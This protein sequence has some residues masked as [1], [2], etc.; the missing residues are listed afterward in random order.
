MNKPFFMRAFDVIPEMEIAVCMV[1]VMGAIIGS[2][3]KQ[4]KDIEYSLLDKWIDDYKNGYKVRIN[5]FIKLLQYNVDDIVNQKGFSFLSCFIKD[6]IKCFAKHLGLTLTIESRPVPKDSRRKYD[7][8]II[9]FIPIIQQIYEIYPII[10][11]GDGAKYE[12]VATLG[13]LNNAYYAVITK[14]G[15]KYKITHEH[16]TLT[17]ASDTDQKYYGDPQFLAIYTRI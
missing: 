11:Q 9:A 15:E 7:S 12:L 3:D 8:D 5:D 1:S 14:D 17:E 4:E 10:N 2:Q 16:S 6:V 13:K